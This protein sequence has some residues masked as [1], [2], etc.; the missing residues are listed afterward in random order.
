VASLILA[1]LHILPSNDLADE[2]DYFRQVSDQRMPAGLWERVTPIMQLTRPR[3]VQL[4]NILHLSTDQLELADRYRLPERVL[5]E[6]LQSPRE[7]W[8]SMIRLSI[9]SQL[10][11]NEV[12]EIAAQPAPLPVNVHQGSKPIPTEPGRESIKTLRRFSR[13]MSSLKPADRNRTLDALA[14]DLVVQ[15]QAENVLI[16]MTDLIRLLQARLK[17]K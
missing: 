11:S 7:Q 9:Q 12:A 6:I 16:L 8:D 15:G 10:T 13:L 5:R 3:M 2:F 4:L 17:G 14:D 1:E